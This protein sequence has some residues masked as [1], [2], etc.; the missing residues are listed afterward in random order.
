[1]NF[2][3]AEGAERCGRAFDFRR[4]RARARVSSSFPAPLARMRARMSAEEKRPKSTSCRAT[5]SAISLKTPV[6]L[7]FFSAAPLI[8]PRAHTRAPARPLCLC[9]P[10][11]LNPSHPRSPS[12]SI[13]SLSRYRCAL[14]G[15]RVSRRGISANPSAKT[16]GKSARARARVVREGKGAARARRGREARG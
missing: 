16:G 1:M 11:L 10:A 4:V 9:S 2:R 7:C 8:A 3:T 5:S 15:S 13:R 12:L 14:S 6:F